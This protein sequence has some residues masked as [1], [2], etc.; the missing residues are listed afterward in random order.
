M[1]HIVKFPVFLA[2]RDCFTRHTAI[3]LLLAVLR[4]GIVRFAGSVLTTRGF[5]IAVT[6][7]VQ[8]RQHTLAYGVDSVLQKWI[9][10]LLEIAGFR[11]AYCAACEVS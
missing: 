7:A 4:A 11:R 2:F 6:R 10:D 5:V 1:I 8:S 3:L 9:S